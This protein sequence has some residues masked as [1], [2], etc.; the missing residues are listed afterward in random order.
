VTLA[1]VVHDPSG[2]ATFVLFKR[3][4]VAL[5]LDVPVMVKFPPAGPVMPVIVNVGPAAGTPAA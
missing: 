4:T 2:V 1:G 5:A 3:T